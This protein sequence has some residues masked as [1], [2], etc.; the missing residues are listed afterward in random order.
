LKPFCKLLSGAKDYI[1]WLLMI[2]LVGGIVP[3]VSLAPG[4]HDLEWLAYR[5]HRK[6]EV[7]RRVISH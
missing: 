1:P 3:S 6:S 7:N 2:G 5:V 4:I